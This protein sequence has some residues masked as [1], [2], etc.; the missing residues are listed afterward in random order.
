[1][2]GVMEKIH[3]VGFVPV[4]ALNNVHKAI[5]LANA[6]EKGGI[7]IIEVTY[8]TE[9][10]PD[11]L[12]EIREACPNVIAGA[13]TI[14]SVEQVKSAVDCG[15]MFIVSPGYDDKIVDYCL[16]NNIPVIP[17]VSNPSEIQHAVQSGLTVLKLFPAESIGGISAINFMAAPFPGI[18]FLPAGGVLMSN[19]GQY[20]SN[21]HVFAC[22]GGFVARANMID[23]E[24]WESVINM[25]QQAMRIALGFEFA[26]VGLNCETA[27]RARGCANSLCTLFNQ[28]A[29]EGNSSIFIETHI[30]L[31]K[32][33]FFGENGHIGFYTNSVERAIYQLGLHGNHVMEDTIRLDGKGRMQSAYLQD[34]VYGFALHVVRK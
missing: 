27:D 4:V 8:R 33:P 13:G 1:M 9:Q 5:G 2:L 25:C 20:L 10:A 12:R 29:K 19:L 14:L 26:H 18:Q 31:M 7:P 22:A 23:N 16:E 30:E 17:G 3:L 15:A 24:D 34:N 32:K 6:L 21:E 28:T 11:C